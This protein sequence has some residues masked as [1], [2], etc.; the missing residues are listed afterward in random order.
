[1]EIG[2]TNAKQAPISSLG[3][4]LQFCRCQVILLS[5]GSRPCCKSREKTLGMTG[6]TSNTGGVDSLKEIESVSSFVVF[7]F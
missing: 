2:V 6:G 4:P 5:S 1:M 3:N 7:T